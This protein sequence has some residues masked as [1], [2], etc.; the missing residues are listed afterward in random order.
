MQNYARVAL[1]G[2]ILIE[3]RPE[4]VMGILFQHYIKTYKHTENE[5]N[6]LYRLSTS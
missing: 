3:K 4:T 1:T 5:N 2:P 6:S